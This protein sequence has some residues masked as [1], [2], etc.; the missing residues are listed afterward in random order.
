MS[1]RD[2]ILHFLYFQT[3]SAH[4]NYLVD[5]R[6]WILRKL[7]RQELKQ[8]VVQPNVFF[9][10][11]RKLKIGQDVSINHGCFISAHGGLEIG[12]Y[13]A[14]GHGT[15]I[16]TTEH[17]YD[18]LDTPIKYQPVTYQ[19]VR[20]GSNV[21]IG[22]RSTILAGVSIASGTIIGAGAVV[23]KSIEQPDTIVAGVPARFLKH[24]VVDRIS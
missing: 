20:I 16:L 17:S 14:I 24:R 9:S 22:A 15:S 12:D 6:R 11:Y 8:L 23:T 19:P 10:G 18:G 4:Y 13:V 2:R 1:L 5:V 7:L 3:M 21:W